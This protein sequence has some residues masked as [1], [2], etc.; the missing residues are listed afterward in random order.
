MKEKIKKILEEKS[1]PEPMSGCWLWLGSINNGGYGSVYF[2]KKWARAHR[3]SF[4]VFKGKIPEKLL[5]CHHCDTR[6]CINPSH[7]FLGTHQDNSTDMVNKG[8]HSNRQVKPRTLSYDEKK[9]LLS[10]RKIAFLRP[11]SHRKED[12]CKLNKDRHLAIMAG[13]GFI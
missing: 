12:S 11:I 13:F 5:V 8:R 7:L 6:S 4:L 2:N 3:V 1:I 9:A 10:A